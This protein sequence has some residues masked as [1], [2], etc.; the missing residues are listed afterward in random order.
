MSSSK[1]KKSPLPVQ[2]ICG[3]QKNAC[4][5]EALVKIL[6]WHFGHSE[7]RGKQLEAIEA[8]LSGN[9]CFCLMPTG[10]GKSMCYQIPALAKKGIV[11][12]VCPLIALMENQVMALKKKGIAAEFLSSTQPLHVREK[13]YKDLDSG[14]PSLKLLYVTP[15][16]IATAGFSSKLSKMYSRGLLQ[17]IAIDEAHCI[18]TWGHDFRPSYRKLSTLRDSLPSVPILALTATAAPKVQRDVIESLCLRNPIVLKSSFNRP[19][20]Y[21]EVRYKDLLDDAFADL[22]GVIKSFGNVCGIVYCLERSACDALAAHLSSNGVSCAAYHAGLNNKLRSSVLDD[23]ISSKIQVVVATVAFGMGIDRKDVRVVCHFNIPKSMESF[24]QESGRAG[25]DQLPSQSILYYGIDDRRRMEFILS[26]A[27]NNKSESNLPDASSKKSLDNFRQM[28]EYCEGHGCRRRKILESFGEQA[29]ASLCPKACDACKQPGLVAKY[30]EELTACTSQQR[31]LLA[32]VFMNRPNNDDG[33]Q[34]SEFW[35]RNNDDS[36]GSEDISDSDEDS[37]VLMSL[38]SSNF[39]SKSR[40]S[41]KLDILEQAEEKYYKNKGSEKQSSKTDKNT[42]SDSLRESSK[43]RLFTALKDAQQ[44]LGSL[45]FDFEAA[46]SSLE[47][48]C[49]KKFGKTGKSFYISQVASTVRWLSTA[50]L[51]HITDRLQ[52]KTPCS[53]N[54]KP[55]D[56]SPSSKTPWSDSSTKA[57]K[58]LYESASSNPPP[59]AQEFDVGITKMVLPPIPSFSEFMRSSKARSSGTAHQSSPSKKHSLDRISNTADKKFRLQ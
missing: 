36:C 18:S 59:N 49:F 30:I 26:N 7:F 4:G 6:R 37:E 24:Y 15:E 8:V 32:Q 2:N 13:I 11:L 38:S 25:R 27:R 57:T 9:D 40:L 20:I 21:Y 56:N 34:F 55:K 41:Q 5:K 14:K 52:P 35:N 19:N 28:I 1:M 53:E 3:T 12:V 54:P 43:H 31:K 29:P 39:S 42:I 58:D 10:G 48:E 50:G 16:L 46:V 47:N 17:L 44:R 33:Q 45:K 22:C 23:W 51:I